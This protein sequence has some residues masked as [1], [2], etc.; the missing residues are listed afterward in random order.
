MPAAAC[1]APTGERPFHDEAA[2]KL[3]PGRLQA[4]FLHGPNGVFD[5]GDRLWIL[6]AGL[7]EGSCPSVPGAAKLVPIDIETSPIGVFG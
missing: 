4:T 6:D 1:S 5:R 7:P 3:D 2:S